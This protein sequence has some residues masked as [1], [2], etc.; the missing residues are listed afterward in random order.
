VRT[1]F[2]PLTGAR[3][4]PPQSGSTAKPEVPAQIR[5][6][7]PTLV[8]ESRNGSDTPDDAP[9]EPVVALDTELRRV[10]PESHNYRWN[11]SIHQ[12]TESAARLVLTVGNGCERHSWSLRSCNADSE[13]SYE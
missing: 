3:N 1:S 2:R 5:V 7:D 8:I 6:L 4:R 10:R 13:R 12:L 9:R 11:S